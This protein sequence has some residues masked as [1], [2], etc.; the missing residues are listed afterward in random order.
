M[1]S[2]GTTQTSVGVAPREFELT[3]AGGLSTGSKTLTV[4]SDNI[5]IFAQSAV[6]RTLLAHCHPAACPV[7]TASCPPCSTGVL[8]QA[9]GAIRP[10]GGNATHWRVKLPAP[11]VD[12]SCVLIFTISDPLGSTQRT[13]TVVVNGVCCVCVRPRS[14][15]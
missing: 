15:C 6:C 7:L 4:A 8:V 2:F 3:A 12:G 5:G 13:L 1:G 14:V 9:S 11:A 10:G